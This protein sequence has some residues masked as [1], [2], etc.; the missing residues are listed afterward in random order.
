[1]L[2]AEI[3]Q[4]QGL[5]QWE[6]AEKLGVTDR[7]VRNYLHPKPKPSEPYQRPSILD[8]FKPFIDSVLEGN[9]GCN[10]ELLIERLQKQ[11]YQGKISILRDYAAAVQ[12]RIE[13][14][15]VIRFETEMGRQAQVD[16]KD[17]GRQVVD[18]KETKMMEMIVERVK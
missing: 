2:K 1:M 13:L 10:R 9:P 4:G 3:L 12:K 8:P 5:K 15:A 6:I 17:F 18:D 16:W 14:Q 7:T 11:G